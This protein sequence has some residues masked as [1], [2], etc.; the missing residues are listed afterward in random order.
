MSTYFEI[1]VHGVIN[2]EEDLVSSF[3][4]DLGA[5]GVSQKL[6]FVQ[7]AANF[8]PIIKN[9]D[10]VTLVAYFEKPI[11]AE[12]LLILKNFCKSVEVKEELQRD[13]IAEWKKHYKIF[14]IVPGHWVV[15]MW[16]SADVPAGKQI[17]IN[18]GLAFGTGTHPTT[19]MM[20]K[21]IDET[22]VA[23]TYNSFL[24]LGAGTGIL[25]IMMYQRGI[26]AGVAAEIDPMAREKCLENFAL[27]QI[28]KIKV[29]DERFVVNTDSRFSLVVANIIDGVLIDLKKSISNSF[30]TTLIVS[31][32]LEERN[33]NFRQKFIES[34]GLKIVSAYKNDI[35]HGY[36]LKR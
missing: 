30:T 4:F 28:S 14:E 18:P 25:S 6:D 13:W 36:V 34:L 35:W 32:I 20:A 22:L 21:M 29:E 17:K 5:S 15:P 10:L 26:Q 3:L 7:T 23:G 8:E 19:Q 24:D 16:L 31:G 11:E 33:E 1:L 12:Q 27:N 9:T 2:A